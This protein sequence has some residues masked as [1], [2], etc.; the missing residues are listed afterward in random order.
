[1]VF[2]V[3][4]CLFLSVYQAA[5]WNLYSIGAAIRLN[6][7]C[8]LGLCNFPLH[9]SVSNT[10][11]RF[12]SGI[13]AGAVF[14]AF[15]GL[16]DFYG[17]ISLEWYRFGESIYTRGSSF[18]VSEQRLVCGICLNRG[19]FCLD[20]FYEQNQGT[21]VE[22]CP[23]FSLIICELALILA[24]ARAGWVSYPLILFICWSVFL[25]F[26]RRADLNHFISDGKIW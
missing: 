2:W 22:D 13:F 26:Q 24:G 23:V 5:V 16:L 12:S 7:F 19:S 6:A 25:F 8:V 15:I 14:C 21:L 10:I 11:N 1:M 3:S 18:H 4:G 17:I 9:L 20:R